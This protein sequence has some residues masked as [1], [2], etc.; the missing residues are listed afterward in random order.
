[1]EKTNRGRWSEAEKSKFSH[2]VRLGLSWKGVAKYVGTRNA[3]QCRSHN[4]KMKLLMY[5]KKPSIPIM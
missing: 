3:D 1:M 2:A 5:N 4:Q